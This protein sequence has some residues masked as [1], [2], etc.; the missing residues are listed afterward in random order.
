M[1]EVAVQNY[2]QSVFLKSSNFNCTVKK[3]T[4]WDPHERKQEVCFKES[5]TGE[6]HGLI[7]LNN[8]KCHS[9]VIANTPV[10]LLLKI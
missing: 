1:S 3:K 2:E 7:Q 8:I 9:N 6:K 4:S 10:D 5:G